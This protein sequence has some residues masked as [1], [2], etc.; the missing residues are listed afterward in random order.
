MGN[1]CGKA[2]ARNQDDDIRTSIKSNSKDKQMPESQQEAM[3]VE[4]L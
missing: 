1:N 3:K 2:A 4:T